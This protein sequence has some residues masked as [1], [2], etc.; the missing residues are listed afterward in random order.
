MESNKT[1]SKL[2]LA[3]GAAILV[4]AFLLLALNAGGGVFAVGPPPPSQ[5]PVG[6]LAPTRPPPL[7]PPPPTQVTYRRRWTCPT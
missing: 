3:L 7:K 5:G 4:G 6:Q 1:R 2:M